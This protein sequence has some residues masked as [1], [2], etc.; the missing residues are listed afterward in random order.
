MCVC[1]CMYVCVCVCVCVCT[2][3]IFAADIRGLAQ[4]ASVVTAL[5][6]MCQSNKDAA[7]ILRDHGATSCTDVTGFG[8]LGHLV[9]MAQASKARVELNLDKVPTITGALEL[10]QQG[11]FSS[12]QPANIRP[13]WMRVSLALSRLMVLTLAPSF[14]PL[15][16]FDGTRVTRAAGVAEGVR[17]GGQWGVRGVKELMNSLSAERESSSTLSPNSSLSLSLSLSFPGPPARLEGEA[18][19]RNTATLVE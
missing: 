11:I 18:Q 14:A 15:L 7:L 3:T 6:G 5:K 8:L 10:V 16:P 4:G 9:E 2:G 19:A 17:G 1:V 12:L 13:S